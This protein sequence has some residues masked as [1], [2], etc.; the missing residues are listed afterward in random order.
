M[1]QG[2]SGRGR[3]VPESRWQMPE[4]TARKRE[5][6]AGEVEDPPRC[7]WRVVRSY[8]PV[9]FLGPLRCAEEGVEAAA[10]AEG[11]R[12]GAA[13]IG[14]ADAVA[15]A[16]RRCCAHL[17]CRFKVDRTGQGDQCPFPSVMT[18]DGEPW[19]GHDA[20]FRRPSGSERDGDGRS[21][22]SSW[23]AVGRDVCAVEAERRT[24]GGPAQQDMGSARF[25]PGMRRVTDGRSAPRSHLCRRTTSRRG[26]GR[27]YNM[28]VR[29]SA[30]KGSKTPRL[31]M[32]TMSRW[33][34]APK[35][36]ALHGTW[37]Q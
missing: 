26:L 9:G 2:G 36:V 37:P 11:H 35:S 28:V 3:D 23:R 34:G 18:V 13:G 20:S 14:D 17:R 29:R 21:P 10:V 22:G 7:V 5:P 24:V 25:S 6:R 31:R 32:R 1:R 4:R 8:D 30:T 15:R 19:E 16:S 33:A 27:L 12:G